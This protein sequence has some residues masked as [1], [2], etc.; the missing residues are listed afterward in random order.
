VEENVK[1]SI[2]TAAILSV[3]LTGGA[4]AQ[5][6][7]DAKRGMTAD[8]FKN[9]KLREVGP[10]LT[11]GRII[12]LA[13]HPEHKATWYVAVASGGVWKTV[14]SGVTWTPLFDDTGSYSVGCITMDPNNPMVLWVG[15]G[16]NNSQRSVGYGDGVYKSTDGGKT[17][18]NMGLKNSEHIGKVLVDPRDSDVV[19]VAA[20]GPLWNPGGDRGLYK[21]TDGGKTWK[22]VLTIS[23]NTGI[24]DIVFDP[25]DPDILYATSYQRR[26][27]VWTMINGGP[28]GG[29]HKTMDGGATWKK[30]MTG[31]P[32]EDIGRI[33]LAISPADPDVIYAIVEAARQTGGFFRSIDGG[34]NWEKRGTYVSGSGQYY[35][36]IFADPKNPD[37]VYSVDVFSRVTDDGGKTW[38]N[39]GNRNRHVDDHVIWIDPDDTDHLLIGGDGGLYE[40]WNR[41]EVWDFKPNL[42]VTQFYRVSVDESRPFYY[43]Y[44]GTQDNFSLGGPSRTGNVHGIA[45]SDWFI[46]R[47]GDGFG[48]VV[49][50][51]DP[52]LV[53]SQ[54]QHGALVRFDRKT[55]ETLDIQPQDE[56]TG[57]AL[58]FN[59]D[60]P[61]IISPH[62][63]TRLY[64]AANRLFR[65]DDRGNSWKAISPDLTRQIDRNK[66]KVMGRYWSIDAVAKNASTSFYG[67]IVSLDESPKQENLVYIG[68]DDGLI[69][70][71]ENAGGSWRKIERFPGVPENTYV[72]NITASQHD[73]GTVFASFDNHKNGDFKPYIL[74]STDKGATWTSIAGDLP[75]RGTV[76]AI[77]QDHVN[78]NLLFV[79]TEFGAFFTL[80]G[81]RKWI[82][83]DSL[84]VIAVRDIAIQRRENDLVLATFGRGFWVLD[85][86]TPLR[87]FKPEILDQQFTLFPVKTTTLY[88]PSQPLGL[89][90]KGFQGERYY[91]AENPPFGA[92]F[93]YY[94]NE[95]VKT[96]RKRRQEADR[97]IEEQSGELFYP[98]WDDLR[99]EDREQ[100]PK[101]LLTVTDAQGNVVRRLTGPL[102]AG[103]H[104]VAWDLR[105]PSAHPTE[106]N[107]TPSDMAIFSDPPWGPMAAP[108]RYTVTASLW[109]EGQIRPVGQPQTFEVAPANNATL[110]VENWTEW[111]SF[112]RQTAS[113][114][115]AVLGATETIDEAH[116]RLNLLQQALIDTPGGNPDLLRQTEVLRNRVRDIEMALEGDSVVSG[117]NEPTLPAIE[118]RVNS[119][120]DGSW[121][122]T[123]APTQTLRENYRI[124]SEAFAPVLQ[125]LR[126]VVGDIQKL[127]AQAEGLGA[128][129]TSG[130]VPDWKPQ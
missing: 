103:F 89:R 65:T 16:E 4:Y 5:K 22:P 14:N 61:V 12:D 24:S 96:L 59:W 90:G 79:G 27:H 2:A 120:V 94:L 48:T 113:L 31:L 74:R 44:G 37:R 35:Q 75:A 102:T 108:G 98:T 112:L 18:T 13:V 84:P 43:I 68:T 111:Q 20:Q 40:T 47:G 67:N 49:D 72:S 83:F 55:G 10:A 125:Q 66:L 122:S 11:S 19:Y 99:T 6:G 9:L 78:P 105:F 114:Q 58:R 100:A 95:E 50:P 115:R 76:Y 69:Q 93:T 92:V 71:T 80:D 123:S 77:A 85:D 52:N 88:S 30:V 39:I 70:V 101:M 25:R 7:N 32:K 29:I 53:Y 51:K 36:E 130:R 1:R 109:A 38:K 82:Q 107:A 42:P 60:S 46:T 17:W 62:A 34:S 126:T 81:G 127:E 63:N 87:T 33:G 118:D 129:W 45:N 64:F 57:A 73:A 110:P 54:A 21:T 3:V 28:E 128:P 15:S 86:Y 56:V 41:G 91:T 26:R 117:R 119:I 8:T 23:E 124:A 116:E 121:A 104:R 106:L 97:K